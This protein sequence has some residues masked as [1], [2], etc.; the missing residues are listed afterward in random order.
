[1]KVRRATAKVIMR[2]ERKV[3]LRAA[4]KPSSRKAKCSKDSA[5]IA[6]VL[7]IE[8]EEVD[9]CNPHL[10]LQA[11]ICT[12][13]ISTTISCFEKYREIKKRIANENRAL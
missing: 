6:P 3:R 1:M 11:M 12:L 10:L 7:P 4:V 13:G 5:G 9:G 8:W 2:P